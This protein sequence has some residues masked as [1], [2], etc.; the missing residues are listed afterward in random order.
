M[1]NL[2]KT[3]IRE[4]ATLPKDC[5]FNVLAYIRFIKLGLDSDEE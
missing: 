5:L 1:T 2:E 4:I 3:I